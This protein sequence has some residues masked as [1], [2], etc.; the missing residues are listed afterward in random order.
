MANQREVLRT[1]RWMVRALAGLAVT[2][3]AVA[4]GC[5]IAS[6]IPRKDRLDRWL[7]G[8][9]VSH[10]PYMVRITNKG[11]ESVKKVRVRSHWDTS[12]DFRRNNERIIGEVRVGTQEF[13]TEGQIKG[14]VGVTTDPAFFVVTGTEIARLIEEG[15]ATK[16]PDYK[17]EFD[18]QQNY[19]INAGYVE[20]IRPLA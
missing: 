13:R 4:A 7:P 8:E 18:P 10:K 14:I 17:G 6:T 3:I 20:K 2:E 15:F 16:N 11:D 5:T 1:R 9:W 12:N 19:Y